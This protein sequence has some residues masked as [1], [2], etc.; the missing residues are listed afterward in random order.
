MV[1]VL[2]NSASRPND[3]EIIARSE[4]LRRA[5]RAAGFKTAQAAAQAF[6][7]N[8]NTYASNENA[9]A[10][11]SFRQASLYAEAFGVNGTWLYTGESPAP[12]R[13]TS[14]RARAAAAL[15]PIPVAIV[16]EVSSDGACH[17]GPVGLIDAIVFPNEGHVLL[18]V[19]PDAAFDLIPAGA[20]IA[21]RPNENPASPDFIGQLVVAGLGNGE[22]VLGKLLQSDDGLRLDNRAGPLAW[23]Q[24]VETIIMPSLVAKIEHAPDAPP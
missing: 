16:G 15:R 8:R 22:T 4:R 9:N 21:F 18:K 6:G 20:L 11:F 19:G 12:P 7:W 14:R 3:A 17:L 23:V 1:Q 13:P 5:R 10:A 2:S 24:P